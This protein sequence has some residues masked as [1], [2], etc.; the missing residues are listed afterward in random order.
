REQEAQILKKLRTQYGLRG[1]ERLCGVGLLKR[2]G[3]PTRKTKGIDNF[4]STSHVAALP[5]LNRLKGKQAANDYV[6]VLKKLLGI[7]DHE[8]KAYL[9]HIP[10]Y[11]TLR[12][13]EF[14]S[15]ADGLV[16]YVGHL[17]FKERL[18]EFFPEESKRKVAEAAF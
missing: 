13:N 15:Q 6:D 12:Q 16:F 9:G 7:D 10:K 8:V 18:R 2:H 1:K 17:L 5:L 4:Y 14:F 3:K 11:A